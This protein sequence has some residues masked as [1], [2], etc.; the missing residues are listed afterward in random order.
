MHVDRRQAETPLPIFGGSARGRERPTAATPLSRAGG[1]KRKAIRDSPR[2]RQRQGTERWPTADT[3]P[4][5]TPNLAVVVA[6]ER[7]VYVQLLDEAV[8][9]WRPVVAV[10]EADD[11]Y[12]LPDAAPTDGRWEFSPGARVRCESRE[13]D[14]EVVLVATALA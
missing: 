11:V 1:P 5:A 14:G 3:P 4:L 13:F 6:T 8:D 7:T 9:V 10:A 12:R 2:A